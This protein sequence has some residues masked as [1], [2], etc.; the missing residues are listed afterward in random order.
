MEQAFFGDVYANRK[1]AGKSEGHPIIENYAL[2]SHAS[3]H[4]R[5]DVTP[6][7][8]AHNCDYRTPG[9]Y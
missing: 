7:A 1:S 8:P 2:V 6:H 3:R 4:L 9:V 5:S